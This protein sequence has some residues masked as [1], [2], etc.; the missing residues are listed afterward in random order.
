MLGRSDNILH[1]ELIA[2]VRKIALNNNNY[3][4]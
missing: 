3:E 1:L 2:D 4:H